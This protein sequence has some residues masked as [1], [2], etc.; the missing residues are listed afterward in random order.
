MFENIRK[1]LQS[2]AQKQKNKELLEFIYEYIDNAIKGED[3]SVLSNKIN[4]II[5]QGAD[6]NLTEKATE[7]S[8]LMLICEYDLFELIYLLNSNGQLDLNKQ[9]KLGRTAMMHA[10]IN[11]CV[12]SFKVLK[13]MGADMTVQDN[14]GKTVYDKAKA[15]GGEIFAIITESEK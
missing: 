8:L 7:S 6:V 12:N 9:D 11:N 13:I 3:N 15:K 2:K 4:K 10:V 14:F 1:K 5:E